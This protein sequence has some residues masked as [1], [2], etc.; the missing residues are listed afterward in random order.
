[1]GIFIF[2][3][4]GG[5]ELHPKDLVKASASASIV[6]LFG[7]LIPFGLGMEFGW[8]VLPESPFHFAQSLFLGTAL[9]I[10][11]VPVAIK[12]LMDMKL[13]ETPLGRLI[14]SAAVIDDVLSLVLLA[15]KLGMH[16]DLEALWNIPGTVFMLILV[17][18][19]GKVVGAGLS[20]RMVGFFAVVIMA[21]VTALGIPAALRMTLNKGR[22]R[23][24]AAP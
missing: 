8:L 14:I 7:M 3:L 11:A 22:C 13:L 20:A 15:E 5:I 19:L 9:A 24:R 1:M 21:V 18:S 10:T 16:L 4:L 23:D 12:V 2:M 17:A 6:A